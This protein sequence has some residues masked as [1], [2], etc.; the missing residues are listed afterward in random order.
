M[1]RIPSLVGVGRNRTG[2]SKWGRG[3]NL[4]TGGVI[5]KGIVILVLGR[6]F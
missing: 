1:G 6:G 5:D 4:E 3:H 2:C